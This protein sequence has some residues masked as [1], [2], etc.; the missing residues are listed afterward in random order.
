MFLTL[1]INIGGH[2]NASELLMD[3]LMYITC[4]H[5]NELFQLINEM[6]TSIK[7]IQCRTDS[8]AHRKGAEPSLRVVNGVREVDR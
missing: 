1:N 6:M 5:T 8:M 4:T 3:P 7:P 2:I